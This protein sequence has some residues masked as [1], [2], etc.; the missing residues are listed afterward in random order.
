[1]KNSFYFLGILILLGSCASL[2]KSQIESVNQFGKTTNNFSAYPSKV[3]AGLA[4]IRTKRSVYYASSLSDP[5]LHISVLDSIYSN[6]NHAKEVSEKV[7][8]TFKIIDKY[9][10]SLV[11]LSSDKYEK[12]LSEQA[13]RFGLSLDSLITVYNNL[14]NTENL[15]TGIGPAVNKLVIMGGQQYIRSKQAKYVKEFVPK[16]DTLIS[17]MTSNLLNFLQSANIDELIEAE[18][19]GVQSNYLSYLRHAHNKSTD[20]DKAY[21]ELLKSLDR[22][23]ALRAQTV[24][25]TK[26]LRAAHKKLLLE[27]REKKKLEES[28]A[29]LDALYEQ[30]KELKSLISKIDNPK[31]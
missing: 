17:V 25:A 10:Q 23:K 19:T 15:P 27:I 29:E 11:L 3:M 18:E 21:L 24:E 30:I 14:D 2:S 13:E 16:A 20:D 6:A 9:A 12:D 5:K 22:V 7:D 31:S 1:M 8:I 4:D 26:D 28:I